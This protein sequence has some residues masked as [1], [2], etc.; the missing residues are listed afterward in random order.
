MELLK[1]LVSGYV[2]LTGIQAV[3]AIE[4]RLSSYL[5]SRIHTEGS[6]I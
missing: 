5:I 3:E 1:R 2:S 6:W 4:R